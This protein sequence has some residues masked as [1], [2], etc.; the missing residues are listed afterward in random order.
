MRET[1][2]ADPP[3]ALQRSARRLLDGRT[4]LVLGLLV[5]GVGSYLY[6][7][8]GGR[9]L[10]PD[11]FALVSVMWAL[12]FLVGNG[13]F[14]PVE[15]ELARSIASDAAG[16]RLRPAVGGSV[17]QILAAAG[18]LALAACVVAV[19]CSGVL[20]ASLFRG[21]PGFVAAFVVGLLGVAATFVVRGVLAG[22]G[23]YV[24]YGAMFAADAVAKAVPALLLAAR[25]VDSPVAYAWVMAGS[26]Y[27]GIVVALL[28]ARPVGLPP[29]RGPTAWSGVVSSLAF[30][31]LTSV[32][33]LTLINLGT[34][35]VELLSDPREGTAA[36]VFLS[37]L[38]IA[39]IPLFLFQALQAVILPRLSA[40]AAIGDRR[41][42]ERDLRWLTTGLVVLTAAA[43]LAAAAVGP[44]VVS[45]LFG[46]EF[47]LIDGWDMALLALASML[48]TATLTL[49]QAQ[50][51]L[52]R[53]RES[54]WPWVAGLVVFT[55][56][57]A[58]HRSELL[59]RVEWAM[60]WSAVAAVL[61][62]A[63]SLRRAVGE[64]R[65]DPQDQDAA[66]ATSGAGE[67]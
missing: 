66:G 2:A 36:G 27:A 52:H 32:A 60:V 26:A 42:F 54:W 50:I 17:R 21:E 55:L 9:A 64:L 35:T 39:R 53:Q 38:V 4:V 24:A 10:G 1:D 25:G 57:A 30:L 37:A 59:T 22:T 28:T 44:A 5:D 61:V 51:A 33:S 12:L 15:Q 20:R 48:L 3:G 40:S 7:S 56:V 29:D 47:D 63:A 65:A 67:Q 16:G 14:I 45:I 18:G 43:T 11:R 13:L 19:A 31:L 8:A 34:V 49:N 46:S 62:A 23:H 6:L 58:N 41:S